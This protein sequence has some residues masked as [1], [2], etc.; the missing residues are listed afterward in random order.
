[1]IVNNARSDLK[2]IKFVAIYCLFHVCIYSMQIIITI[3]I[4]INNALG[5]L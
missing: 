3:C 2:H 4:I 5:K 1:M